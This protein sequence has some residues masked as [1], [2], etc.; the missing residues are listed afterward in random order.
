M[1]E[2]EVKAKVR[3]LEEVKQKLSALGCVFSEPVLQDDRIYL[4]N[5]IEF[6]DIKKGTVN[7]FHF[8]IADS[9]TVSWLPLLGNPEFESR[10]E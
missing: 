1:K 4:H 2:I 8:Y 10:I 9:R 5:S 7:L 3:N 6:E